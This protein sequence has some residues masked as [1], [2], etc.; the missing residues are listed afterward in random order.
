MMKCY[1]LFDAESFKGS[2]GMTY[3]ITN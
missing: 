2:E 1:D 3:K